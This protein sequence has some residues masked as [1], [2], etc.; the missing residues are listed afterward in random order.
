M[1]IISTEMQDLVSFLLGE[2]CHRDDD[3]WERKIQKRNKGLMKERIQVVDRKVKWCLNTQVFMRYWGHWHIWSNSNVWMYLVWCRIFVVA[4][5]SNWPGELEKL[6][7]WKL[8]NYGV[9]VQKYSPKPPLFCPCGQVGC[10]SILGGQEGVSTHYC[11][12]VSAQFGHVSPVFKVSP[13]VSPCLS[14]TTSYKSIASFS[15]LPRYLPHPHA[16]S[17]WNPL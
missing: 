14:L 12:L 8:V 1:I 16:L 15:P 6:I 11:S 13:A 7:I 10:Y 3:V 2:S 9:V 17:C 4:Q 5:Q